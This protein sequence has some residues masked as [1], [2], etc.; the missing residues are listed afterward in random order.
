MRREYAARRAQV[1]A[2]LR[3]MP[4]VRVLAAGGRLLRDGGRARDRAVVRTTSGG[5]CSSEH[6][7]VVVHGS[8]YGAGGEGTLRVSFA[9]GGDTLARGLERLRAGLS[10]L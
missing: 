5:A 1:I 4:R 6:G 10:R 2:A 8:A 3:G 7:V 9:S